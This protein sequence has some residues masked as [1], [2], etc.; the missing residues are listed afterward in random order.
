VE[1]SKMWLE[2]NGKEKPGEGSKDKIQN[3]KMIRENETP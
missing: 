3:D 1:L 2:R